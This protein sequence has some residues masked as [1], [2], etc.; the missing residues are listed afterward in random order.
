MCDTAPAHMYAGWD[1]YDMA[2]AP[3]NIQLLPTKYRMYEIMQ[4]RGLSEM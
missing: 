4:N 2:L 3:Q 1:L